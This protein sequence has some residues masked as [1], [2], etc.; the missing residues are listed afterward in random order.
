MYGTFYGEG[1]VIGIVILSIIYGWLFAKIMRYSEQFTTD[2]RYMIKGIVI[3]SFLALIRGGD[4][5][6]IVAFVGMSY[7]PIF[8]FMRQYSIFAKRFDTWYWKQYLVMKRF[9]KQEDNAPT[10]ENAVADA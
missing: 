4:L 8:L 1:G 5:A 6:G 10:L 9:A 2:I 3:A 7:W